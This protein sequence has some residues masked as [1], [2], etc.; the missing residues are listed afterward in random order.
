[1][2]SAV[3]VM[4]VTSGV[5]NTAR[6]SI[7]SVFAQT[8]CGPIMIWVV[9]DRTCA[10]RTWCDALAAPAH[11]ALSHRTV[12]PGPARG[13]GHA[14]RRVSHLR[15][16][17]IGFGTAP[18][19]AFIDDDNLWAPDHLA[20]LVDVL[21]TSRARAAHSWR[22]VIDDCGRAVRLTRYV[23]RDPADPAGRALF[24]LYRRAGVFSPH[25]AIVRDRVSVVD[26]GADYGMVDM[27]EWLFRRSFFDTFRFPDRFTQRDLDQMVGEDD[28]LLA[29][30]RAT[31]TPT[32][33]T[34]RA[35]LDYRLGGFSNAWD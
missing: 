12:D 21:G 6:A 34:A 22:R 30:V 14:L 17:A 28:V 35:T 11:V 5:R 23:W 4:M 31:G 27:G 25:D 19:I 16:C 8:Y 15:N 2:K 3:D 29:H 20:S 26:G 10:A 7:E 32:A 24:A 9:E 13:R 33:C 1:M 18:L